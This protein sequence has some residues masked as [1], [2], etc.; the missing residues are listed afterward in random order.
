MSDFA[1]R[2][3]R[4][5]VIQAIFDQLTEGIFLYDEH[6]HLVGVN[7]SGERL[8]GLPADDMLGKPCWTLFRVTACEPNETQSSGSSQSEAL[9]AGTVKL[10]L[11]NGQER[12]IVLRNI[13]LRDEYGALE[14]V[15][16]TATDITAGS[17][18]NGRELPA[19]A[20]A[21]GGPM[22]RFPREWA[23]KANL[24]IPPKR[25]AFI[26][27]G[28]LLLIFIAVL[29]AGRYLSPGARTLTPQEQ[30]RA[31]EK[32]KREALARFNAMT[33]AQHIERAILA[34]KPG[35]PAGTIS[36]GLRHL[37]AIPNS[38]PESFRAKALERDLVKAQNL[39][40][41]GS[42]IDAASNSE[43]RDGV[44]KLQ[45]AEGLLRQYPN[46]KDAAKLS[47]AVRNAAEQLAIRSPEDFA[48]S[49]ARLVDFTWEKGGFGTV[50][51]AN[52]TVR[53]DSPVDVAD[54]RIRCNHIAEDGVV[55][56][57]NAG[58]AY[59][60]IKAHSTTRI[61]N[62]NMGFLSGQTASSRH[63]KTNCEIVTLKVASESEGF[64]SPR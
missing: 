34:L 27:G 45:R 50:M 49:E 8:L 58:T 30:Q 33:P 56:D 41:A 37:Q 55:L 48:T 32:Q 38:A 47:G 6:L 39:A 11:D 10:L 46:D 54:P 20:F 15:V 43:V 14:G 25:R 9:P 16:A 44:D 53:N 3:Q 7:P 62:V 52:F 5:E 24:T 42:L 23:V 19:P 60:V 61:A 2:W 17:W 57:Q 40:S 63:T 26:L 4:P 51:M 59:G 64:G 22:R 18:Q 21:L 29:V 36:D 1:R 28:V 12:L 35:A 31:A 13:E